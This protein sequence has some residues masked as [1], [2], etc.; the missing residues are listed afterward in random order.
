MSVSEVKASSKFVNNF[1][2]V[3]KHYLCTKEE[4][5]EMK[6]CAR[7]DM[8]AAEESFGLMADEISR[9]SKS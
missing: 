8:Q 3:S 9:M 1:M 2:F 5:E 6:Q 7:N 4:I